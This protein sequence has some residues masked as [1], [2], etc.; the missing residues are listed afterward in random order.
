[1]LNYPVNTE[2]NISI[3]F[4]YP[5]TCV[6]MLKLSFRLCFLCTKI[7][8]SIKNYVH[9]EK[10]YLHQDIEYGYIFC[11]NVLMPMLGGN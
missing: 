1:M 8:G 9:R 11:K 10:N 4:H 3:H 5:H 2:D 6:F 7:S